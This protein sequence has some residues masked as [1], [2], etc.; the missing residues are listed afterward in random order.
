MPFIL[1]PTSRKMGCLAEAGPSIKGIRPAKSKLVAGDPTGQR[2][3][4]A[5]RVSGELVG[6]HSL[7]DWGILPWNDT[8]TTLLSQPVPQQ[9]HPIFT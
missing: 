9:L 7:L 8:P 5:Y 2:Y 4:A 6:W 3:G 1:R